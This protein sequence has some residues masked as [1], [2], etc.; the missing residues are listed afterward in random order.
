MSKTIAPADSVLT[1]AM[2]DAAT[3]AGI[4]VAFAACEIRRA[5]DAAS[6]QRRSNASAVG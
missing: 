3:V 1:L 2:P 4:C 5:R 6:G